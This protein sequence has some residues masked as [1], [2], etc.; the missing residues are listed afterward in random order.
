MRWE[1]AT[2]LTL[3]TT[4]MMQK[5]PDGLRGWVRKICV[6]VY[7][8]LGTN[9]IYPTRC[10]RRRHCCEMTHLKLL[11][12][13]YFW[14]VGSVCQQDQFVLVC[15]AVLFLGNGEN[16]NFKRQI[17]CYKN[18][19]TRDCLHQVAFVLHLCKVDRYSEA[20]ARCCIRSLN[21]QTFIKLYRNVCC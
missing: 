13:K 5:T 10:S 14:T 17:F 6:H 2:D 1:K 18:V 20:T 3:S 7:H 21:N 4:P 9:L 16:N 11:S 19:Y 12:R 15:M 8:H